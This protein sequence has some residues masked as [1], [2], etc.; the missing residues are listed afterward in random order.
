MFTGLVK[1]GVFTENSLKRN[2]KPF[3]WKISIEYRYSTE[4]S[5]MLF[6]TIRTRTLPQIW[7][8]QVVKSGFKVLTMLCNNLPPKIF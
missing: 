2:E 1:V 8:L 4:S 5:A 7:R 6:V 3:I